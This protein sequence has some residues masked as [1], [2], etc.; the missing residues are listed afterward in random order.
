[1]QQW[2]DMLHSCPL[3]WKKRDDIITFE[4][5]KKEGRN[6]AMKLFNV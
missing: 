2:T 3:S 1:M 4:N 6:C 5:K